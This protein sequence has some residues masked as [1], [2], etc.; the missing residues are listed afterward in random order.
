MET[1]TDLQDLAQEIIEAETVE[2][3]RKLYER[4]K[5]TS[6]SVDLTEEIEPVAVA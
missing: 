3:R 4:L 6:T 5:S 1:M 2:Q